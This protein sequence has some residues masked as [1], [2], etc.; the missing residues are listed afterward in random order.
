MNEAGRSLRVFISY[1]RKDC[2]PFA[3]ELLAGLE[4][5]GFDAFLNRHDINAGEPWDN[6]LRNLIQQADTV[7]VV[8]SPESVASVRCTWEVNLADSLSKR[9]LPVV[10]I[11]VPEAQT[12]DKLKRLNYILFSRLS[13]GAAL[14]DLSVALRT[15]LAWVREHTRLADSHSDGLSGKSPRNSCSA[16][17]SSKGPRR[18]SLARK[19]GTPKRPRTSVISS[20][21]AKRRNDCAR[22]PSESSSTKSRGHRPIASAP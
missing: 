11:E 8:L 17:P 16:V 19:P 14:R 6:R 3:E 12:P 22:A 21:R 1:A 13:F 15:N 5:A 18:G 9:L 7:V 10:A 2:N 4:A 20:T